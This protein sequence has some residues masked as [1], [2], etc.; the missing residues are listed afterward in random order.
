MKAFSRNNNRGRA[1]GT[2]ELM[3]KRKKGQADREPTHC[4]HIPNTLTTP[5]YNLQSC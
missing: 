5:Q 4:Q 1:Q 2:G 3:L